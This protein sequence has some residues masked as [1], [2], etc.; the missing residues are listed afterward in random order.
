VSIQHR[1]VNDAA[2]EGNHGALLKIS[3]FKVRRDDDDHDDHDR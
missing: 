2:G 1:A 3:G